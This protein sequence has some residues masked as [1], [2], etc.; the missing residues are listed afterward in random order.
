MASSL[1]AL[2]W[3]AVVTAQPQPVAGPSLEYSDE[4]V[5]TAQK[6]AQRASDIGITINA[7]SNET[8]DKANV[9]TAAQLIKIT[10]ALDVSGNNAGQILSFSIRG[11]TQQDVSAQA[12]GPRR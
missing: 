5:V 3:P 12:E 10:P 6:R 11:V 1:V 9:T 4:I 2:A 7:Y 8:L